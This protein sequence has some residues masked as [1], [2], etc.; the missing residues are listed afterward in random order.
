QGAPF[1]DV[2]LVALRYRLEL[3]DSTARS[4]QVV[5]G[6]GDVDRCRQQPSPCRLIR[7]A[8]AGRRC[9]QRSRDRA[10]RIVELAA[11]QMEERQAGL[12]VVAELVGTLE[13]L[14]RAVQVAH[15][16]P[17]LPDLVVGESQAVVQAEPL[18]L[19]AGLTRFQRVLRPLAAQHL[20]LRSVDTADARIAAECLTAHPALALVRPL[21]RA[22]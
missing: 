14:G 21:G 13:R 9:S 19:L 4:V 2:R 8:L 22:L 15:A 5:A 7:R 17:D 6:E 11:R 16:K 3:I 10:P 18:K 12:P 20:Q 1:E